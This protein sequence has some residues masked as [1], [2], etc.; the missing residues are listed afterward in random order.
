VRT[1]EFLGVWEAEIERIYRLKK[2]PSV[3][4]SEHRHIDEVKRY[5]EG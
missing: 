3:K 2:V 4:G 5:P 1:R